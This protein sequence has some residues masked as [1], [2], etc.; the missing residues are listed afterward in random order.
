[1][2]KVRRKA[3][4]SK[5]GS[6]VRT[7]GGVQYRLEPMRGK[8]T[9]QRSK[10]EGIRCRT[11]G[12]KVYRLRAV[13][14]ASSPGT[15]P[16][17]D[18]DE[19]A[20]VAVSILPPPKK[21]KKQLVGSQPLEK[22][23]MALPWALAAGFAALALRRQKASASPPHSPPLHSPPPPLDR[24]PAAA[25]MDPLGLM[26]EAP[27]DP[28][29]GALDPLPKRDPDPP[30]SPPTSSP[31]TSKPNAKPTAVPGYERAKNADVTSAMVKSAIDVLSRARA[32]AKQS[33]WSGQGG[34]PDTGP[35]PCGQV[36]YF[37]DPDSGRK[38]AVLIE[39]HYHEPG[40]PIKPWGHHP[41][42]SVFVQ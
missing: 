14:G 27:M 11:L 5:V 17:A 3:V 40:G 35:T 8:C 15:T 28:P 22:W 38:Y 18:S 13:D 19:L 42:A 33:G 1:M 12:G 39:P 4:R 10:R 20:A 30:S 7:Y 23:R 26:P 37:I 29:A 6:K 34:C 41:G 16:P 32:D 36:E 25:P 9:P 21:P 24:R 31:P 2:A